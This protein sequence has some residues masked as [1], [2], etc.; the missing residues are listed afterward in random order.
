MLNINKKQIISCC[1]RLSAF[2]ILM[3]RPLY[4]VLS[5]L[6]RIY[7]SEVFDFLPMC[8]NHYILNRGEAVYIIN[9]A[10]NCISSTR[11]VVYHQAAGRYT[12]ARDEIQPQKG[13]WYAP[14][15]ARWWYAKPA[16]WIKKEV[17]FGKQKLLL[18]WPARRDS[19]PRPLESESTAI[20]S[21]ATGG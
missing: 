12:L 14:R 17:T 8:S 15:F 5:F 4:C 7:K 3:R 9:S 11:S 1:E 19:N 13:W 16:A 18:F 21:F 20:S 10:R 2:I 6:E